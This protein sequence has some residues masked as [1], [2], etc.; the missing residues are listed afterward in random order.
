MAF[1]IGGVVALILER[2]LS[3]IHLNKIMSLLGH[4]RDNQD[5][6]FVSI[7]HNR[8][9]FFDDLFNNTLPHVRSEL[10][11]MGI[12]VSLFRESDRAD[13]IGKW[14]K[15]H[16]IKTLVDMAERGCR[17]QIL[18]LK[19]YPT[20][21][22]LRQYG[23]SQEAD[24]Y[25][26]RERDEDPDYNFLGG[27]RLKK[28]A[29]N[30]MGHWISVLI[31]LTR[32]TQDMGKEDRKEILNRL[33]IREYISLPSLSLYIADDEIFVTPY[34]YKRHCATVPTFRIVGK[35]TPLYN[36][37]NE[38]FEATWADPNFTTSAVKEEF[39]Q[40][41][42]DEPK[43]ALALYTK[44]YEEIAAQ[45]KIRVNHNIDRLQDPEHYRV[46]ENAIKAVLA[47]FGTS[48]YQGIEVSKAQ[49]LN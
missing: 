15:K 24:F 14:M 7:Y 43:K 31:E 18:F 40:L 3:E 4:H 29:N 48:R 47:E 9:R 38:H 36:S 23:V 1:A 32:R 33:Q 27:R 2:S 34:L 42:I 17:I 19:R 20:V 26:M 16:T 10:K 45:E 12:C 37:Y 8:Q 46:E 35:V 13:R 25:F 44:K 28:I 39:L 30:S 5:A 21:S 6:G 41:L 49:M 11:V 22:E